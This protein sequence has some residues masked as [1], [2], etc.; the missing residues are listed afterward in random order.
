MQKIIRLLAF[1]CAL[2]VGQHISLA[3][4]NFDKEISEIAN[5]VTNRMGN[6]NVKNIAVVDMTNSDE[7]TVSKLGK[8]LAKEIAYSLTNIPNKKFDII[9]R[10]RVNILMKEVGL[11]GKGLLDAESKPKLGK[12]KGIDAVLVGNIT[13][14]G[15]SVRI[16]LNILQLE[17]ASTLASVKGDIS[18]TQTIID[19]MKNEG[20]SPCKDCPPQPDEEKPKLPPPPPIATHG[21]YDIIVE[22]LD[23]VQ[24][25]T[26]V[27]LSMRIK[28]KHD[29]RIGIYISNRSQIFDLDANEYYPNKAKI[30]DAVGGTDGVV[31]KLLVANLPTKASMNFTVNN[32]KHLKFP[33]ISL[34]I[35]GDG[36]A[37]YDAI[38]RDVPVRQK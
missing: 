32:Q 27:E 24:T 7:I 38:F 10:S 28:S 8:Y 33:K 30:A 5:Q 35:F 14:L 21:Q 2:S 15:N 37:S 11:E 19:L 25:G 34:H 6:L 12:I 1:C 20:E 18:K 3:Q 23:C 16:F 17:T 13:D 31:Q 22:L 29:R 9:D 36:F 26:S 4:S